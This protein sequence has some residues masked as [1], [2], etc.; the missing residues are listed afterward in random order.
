MSS[1][2][3][4]SPDKETAPEKTADESCLC[5]FE[6][7]SVNEIN[8]GRLLESGMLADF[9]KMNGGHWDHFK[10]LGLCD[11]ISVK[12]YMPVDL[13][14]VGLELERIKAGYFRKG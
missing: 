12:G 10:W 6:C 2:R 11:N 1:E 8:L 14:K 9:V 7:P 5:S 4:S 3:E 13:D